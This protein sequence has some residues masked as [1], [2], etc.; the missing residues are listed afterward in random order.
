MLVRTRFDWYIILYD[1]WW[2]ATLAALIATLVVVM[3]V[4]F[5]RYGLGL[6]ASYVALMGTAITI[7]LGFKNNSAYERWWE[8]RILWGAIVNDSRSLAR[9]VLAL[10]TADPDGVAPTPWQ[11]RVVMRQIAFVNALRLHLRDRGAPEGYTD[12]VGADETIALANA[13]NAPAA[14]LESQSRDIA[15]ARAAGQLDGY[16]HMVIEQ[17]LTKLTDSFGACERIKRTPFPRQYDDFAQFIV[18][19]FCL[20]FPFSL[21]R[22][23]AF[24]T[25]PASVVVV[26]AFQVLERI[27]SN[28]QNPFEGTIHDTP[29]TALCRTIE[30]DLCFSLGEPVP[31]PVQPR[32]GILM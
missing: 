29:M 26:F 24:W 5:D 10:P 30:R 17:T 18:W 15:Q 12:W 1:T 7:L 11:R 28:I 21:V 3:D 6:P 16:S 19:L 20:I 4:L 27:G 9:Q 25:I 31:E 2:P 23:L 13:P 8:A 14:L 32:R 22:E